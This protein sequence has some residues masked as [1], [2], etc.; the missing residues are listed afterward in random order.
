MLRSYTVKYTKIGS[1]YMGQL[2]EWPEVITEGK[3][4][5]DCRVM[6]RDAIREMTLAY[7]QQQKEIPLGGCLI[8]QVPV[9]VD[10]VYQ[11]A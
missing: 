1:V 6:I 10:N 11:A 5:E 7:Q 4:I 9:E 8:E 3:N 2:I